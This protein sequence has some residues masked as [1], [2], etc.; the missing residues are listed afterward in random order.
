LFNFSHLS[1]ALMISRFVPKIG[2]QLLN[3]TGRFYAAMGAAVV[4]IA[5]LA[6]FGSMTISDLLI[7]RKQAEL[8]SL[9]EAA[10]SIVADY[11]ARASRGE[12]AADEARKRA[13]D[14][15]R[16]LR[17]NGSEYFFVF[18]YDGVNIVHPFNK[19]LEGKNQ[20]GLKDSTG[21]AFAKKIVERAR[22]GGGFVPY[23]WPRPNQ[24][25]PSPKL[26]YA[27]AFDKWQWVIGTGDYVDDL[28]VIAAAK[29][30]LFLFLVAAA[31]LALGA[32][33]FAFGRSISRPIHRLVASMAALA[34]GRLDTKVE[35]VTRQDEIGVMARAVR[36]FQEAMLA[37]READEAAAAEAD[38]KARRAHRLDQLTRQ[39]ETNVS[40]LTR[41]LSGA[42]GGME[43]TAQSMAAVALQTNMQS[44]TVA[45][46][47]EQTSANVQTVAAAAEELS[48]ST[49]EIASQVAHSTRIAGTAV[50]D[51]KCTDVTVRALAANAERI[52]NVVALINMIA[53]Q[54]NLL[55]LNATIEAARA[56]EAGRGFAV[57][58]SEVKELAGQTTKATEEISTQ[59]AEIQK[60]TREAVA[61][62]QS[63][64]RRIAE[65]SNVSTSIAAAIEEQGAATNEIAR[66]V[67]EAARGTEAVTG[68]IVDVK[69][70]ASQTGAAASQVLAA[71]QSLTGHS[72][73][74]GREVD[75]FLSAVK[76]A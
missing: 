63:I 33:A 8:K 38:A 53:S 2:Q 21:R 58:A 3:V 26:S 51:A 57:V 62:I 56:G 68:N 27:A 28:A 55:A 23:S 45:S 9:S 40:A 50:E 46:A 60:V 37:K 15:L 70:G 10:T 49:Q 35:G 32:V 6:M 36:V 43:I 61:A 1:G 19:A 76:A 25:E 39:F 69:N 54:T 29:R 12:M 66:N 31:A 18:D 48:I 72:R 64:G 22:A 59:I 73:E 4:A 11:E 34:G 14:T 16:A 42:A 30:N 52:G 44:A 20:N 41:A 24:T 71:A 74:L 47:A 7:E 65:M 13:T 17:Y 67:Q 5:A 75:A